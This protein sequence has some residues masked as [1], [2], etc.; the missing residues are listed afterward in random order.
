MVSQTCPK[1]KGQMSQHKASKDVS[2]TY[3]FLKG[4]FTSAMVCNNCGFIEF[5]AKKLPPKQ[6]PENS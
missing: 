6:N 3:G 5:Y 1:C 4:S 2:V